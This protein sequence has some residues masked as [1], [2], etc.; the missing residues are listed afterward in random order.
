MGIRSRRSRT[1]VPTLAVAT[2]VMFGAGTL[3]LVMA[4]ATWTPGKNPQW[5]LT[6]LAALALFLAMGS[7]GLGER[8]T[9]THVLVMVALQL[10][11]VVSLTWTTGLDIAALSNGAV[12]SMIGAFVT[13]FLHPV[14]GRVVLYTGCLGWLVA[15]ASR[16]DASLVGFALGLAAQ[17][18]LAAEAF[19]LIRS[20]FDRLTHTD[21]LTGV[22]S[23]RGITEFAQ[24]ALDQTSR[25]AAPLAVALIDLDGLREVN[26]THGHR[27]GDDLLVAV[28]A[29]WDGRLRPTDRVGRIG[30]DEFLLVLPGT[31]RAEAQRLVAD[32]AIDSPCSWSVGVAVADRGDDLDRLIARADARMYSAKEA[33]RG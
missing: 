22:L 3:L 21:V 11:C 29:D 5:V 28:S 20:R 2:A 25:R 4:V 6:M 24:R 32:L 9:R 1:T 12:L 13:W 17:A 8:L 19:A 14:W 27:A 31:T 15:V 7:I 26:N 18:V 10:A 33:A 23:R 16:D 30:G